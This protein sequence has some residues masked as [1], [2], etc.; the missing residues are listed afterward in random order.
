MRSL[1]FLSGENPD[2][3]LGELK[4]VLKALGGATVAKVDGRAVIFDKEVPDGTAVRMGLCHFSGSLFGTCEAVQPEIEELIGKY[5]DSSNK[6]KSI[7]VKAVSPEGKEHLSTHS[8]FK[9]FDRISRE[10]E[11]KVHHRAPDVRV[12]LIVGSSVYIGTI[13]K[14]TR[15]ELPRKRRGS[16]MPFRRPIVMEPP[17][18]RSMVNLSGLPPGSLIIDPFLGPG[19]LAIEAGHLKYKVIGVEKDPEIL[20]G[21]IS[22]IRS[23]GLEDHIQVHGGDSRY[24]DREDWWKELGDIDGIVTDPPFGRSAPLMGE[25]PSELLREVLSKCGKKLRTGAPLVLDTDREG[26]LQDIDGFE[27]LRTFPFRVH[28]SL[29]R[30]IGLFEKI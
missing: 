8:L 20:N 14:E 10:R 19:G 27:L 1:V 5:L 6:K 11:F 4:G 30:F 3:A 7:S 13:L 25:D 26:N 16:S 2:L 17:L 9:T 18:A 22:N 29:T 24:L 15:R 28:K 12:F 21:A 23:Q